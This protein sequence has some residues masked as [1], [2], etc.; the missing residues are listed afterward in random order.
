MEIM[1]DHLERAPNLDPLPEP[2][3]QV[4]LKA[5]AKDPAKRFPSCRAFVET[6]EDALGSQLGRAARSRIPGSLATLPEGGPS[7]PRGGTLGATVPE[8]AAPSGTAG[9]PHATAAVL[10]GLGP[11]TAPEVTGPQAGWRQSATQPITLQAPPTRRNFL[12]WVAG[13]AAAA[14]IGVGSAVLVP[15]LLKK[16]PE[17]SDGGAAS[18]DDSGDSDTELLRIKPGD[19]RC[20]KSSGAKI[21]SDMNK[22]RFWDRIE[23]PLEDG[24]RVPFV[25]VPQMQTE[26]PPTFYIM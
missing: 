9:D 26:D 14:T 11:A 17:K 13:A 6:L 10:P 20:V 19:L 3:K 15:R 22:H 24:T 25:L 7:V 21:R 12:M 23:Y 2:E 5:L 1:L 16:A 4:V 8:G 18:P